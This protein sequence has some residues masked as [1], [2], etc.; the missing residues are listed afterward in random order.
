MFFDV[1]LPQLLPLSK[2]IQDGMTLHLSFQKV[3]F[4][5]VRLM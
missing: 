2:N 3:M 5:L 1:D 4:R